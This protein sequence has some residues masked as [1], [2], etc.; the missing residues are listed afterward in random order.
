MSGDYEFKLQDEPIIFYSDEITAAKI[1]ALKHK[2]I[3]PHLYSR[4]VN[5]LEELI[6]LE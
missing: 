4:V 6:D 2:G 1:I 5:K 3:K